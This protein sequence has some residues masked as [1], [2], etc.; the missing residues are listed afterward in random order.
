MLGLCRW[1]CSWLRLGGLV[2][3]CSSRCGAAFILFV[4]RCTSCSRIFLTCLVCGSFVCS[5]LVFSCLRRRCSVRFGLV[6]RRFR[7]SRF[8]RFGSVL[9]SLTLS[10]SILSGLIFGRL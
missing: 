8:V 9:R 6:L 7:L 5:G 2:L 3:G 1:L 4:R 10:G